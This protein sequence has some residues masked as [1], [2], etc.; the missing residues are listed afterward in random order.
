[1]KPNWGLQYNSYQ[2]IKENYN[3]VYQYFDIQ[4]N[5]SYENLSKL[6]INYIEKAKMIIEKYKI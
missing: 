5:S 1:M 2:S 6:I 4:N 3:F